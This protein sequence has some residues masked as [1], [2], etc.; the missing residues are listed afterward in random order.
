MDEARTRAL[1]D[2]LLELS[3]SL[4]FADV[5]TRLVRAPLRLGLASGAELA[6]DARETLASAHH[7]E[8]DTRGE[9]ALELELRA[10]GEPLGRLRVF[11]GVAPDAAATQALRRLAQHGGIALANARVHEAALI[12]ADYDSLTGLANFGRISS[13]LEQEF[14][15]AQRYGRAMAV[16]MFDIDDLKRWNDRFGHEAGNVALVGIATLLRERSRASDVAGRW[17]GDEL[18][19]VLPETTTDGAVAVAEKVRA[20][21]ESLTGAERGAALTISAGVASAASDGKTA[22]ELMRVADA[23]LY[24][25]KAAGG[26][27]VIA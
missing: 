25:A 26:N 8:G 19:L 16:V 10:G 15:R 9:P 24:R 23:R 12:R 7:A 5:C 11:A 4:I 13:V 17:G 21:F 20:A 2:A 27:R 6:L 1:L 14:A 3:A 18:V 22:A